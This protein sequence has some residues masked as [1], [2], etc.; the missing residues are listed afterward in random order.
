MSVQEAVD[1]VISRGVS[2]LRKNAFGDD[3]EDAKSLPWTREQAWF[4]MKQ[5]ARQPEVNTNPTWLLGIR[6][7]GLVCCRRSPT[8]K[9]SP[10]S[11]SRTRAMRPLCAA[12]NSPSS[13][14]SALS[15]VSR[16]FPPS[17]HCTD[18]SSRAAVYDQTGQARVQMGLRA[19]GSG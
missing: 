3:V 6:L 7:N 12:W 5:L 8:M 4:L 16:G 1:D 11:R 13:L 9:F 2:E 19:V 18:T 14:Q 15:M 17:L 10:T